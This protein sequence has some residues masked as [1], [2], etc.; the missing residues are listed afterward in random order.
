MGTVSVDDSG[1]VFCLN[2]SGGTWGLGWVRDKRVDSSVDVCSTKVVA[3]PS[4]DWVSRRPD[5]LREITRISTCT[6]DPTGS[7]IGGTGITIGRI[8]STIGR[9]GSTIGRIGST[10]FMKGCR[11]ISSPR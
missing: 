5:A 4:R 3:H 10:I 9:T 7:I 8:G 1:L 11:S 6:I 2:R